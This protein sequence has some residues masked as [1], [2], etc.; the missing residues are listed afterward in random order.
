MHNCNSAR[1]NFVELALAELPP[2]ESQRLLGELNGC[3]ACRVEFAALT[4]TL[5]VSSQAIRSSLPPEE[6]WTGYNQRLQARLSAATENPREQPS[7][8]VPRIPGFWTTLVKFSTARV[9][10]PVP[11]ALAAVL[12]LVG[13]SFMFRARGNAV[14]QPASPLVSVETRIVEVP[15]V[16]E[17]VITRVVYVEK[18]GQRGR[19]GE[20]LENSSAIPNTVARAG[21][22]SNT[23]SLNLVDFKPTDQVQLTV[24]K[25]AYKD[26][27]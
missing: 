21:F 9:H 10:V 27:K 1:T 18:P 8:N 24:I 17:K 12:L 20:S 26:E 2:A 13:S 14:T 5:H 25:G 19:R 11:V 3:D 6:F 23:S 7:S 16:K 15:V 4:S 22:P